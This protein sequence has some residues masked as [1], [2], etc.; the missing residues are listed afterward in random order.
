MHSGEQGFEVV[1]AGARGRLPH[2]GS[3][4]V[5]AQ[6][7]R[8]LALE[9]ADTREPDFVSSDVSSFSRVCQTFLETLNPHNYLLEASDSSHTKSK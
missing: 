9:P 8:S 7:P 1:R 2:L 3:R 4:V 6:G 5:F